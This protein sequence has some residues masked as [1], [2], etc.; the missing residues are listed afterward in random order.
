MHGLIKYRNSG[1]NP[2]M[3]YNNIK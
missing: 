2:E 3:N 1:G